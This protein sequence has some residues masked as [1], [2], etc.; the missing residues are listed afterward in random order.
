MIS[1]VR[2][3]FLY[4][5]G[6]SEGAGDMRVSKLDATSLRL[7]FAVAVSMT[8]GG[9]LERDVAPTPEVSQSTATSSVGSTPASSASPAAARAT[10]IQFAD[11]QKPG[12]G[13]PP[14]ALAYEAAFTLWRGE[15]RGMI[16]RKVAPCT[17]QPTGAPVGVTVEF[18][19]MPVFETNWPSA[20]ELVPG[21][22]YDPLVPTGSVCGSSDWVWADVKVSTDAAPGHYSLTLGDLPVALRVENIK[23]PDRPTV[24]LYIGFQSFSALC[25]HRLDRNSP[26]RDQGPLVKK[27]VDLLRA[28]RIEPFG[29]SLA[30]PKIRDGRP[31]ID[32]WQELGGSFRQLVIDGA[33]APPM[34]LSGPF[35]SEKWELRPRNWEL[36]RALPAWER[37]VRSSTAFA[38]SWVYVT[39]EPCEGEDCGNNPDPGLAGT[40]ARAQLLR[41]YAPSLRRMVTHAPDSRLADVIDVFVPL[42]E[43]FKSKEIEKLRRDQSFWIY[44]SCAS[45]THCN[46]VI[47]GEGT[48]SPDLMLD[49]PSIHARAFPIVAAALGAKAAL[50]YTANEGYGKRDVWTDQFDFGGNGDGQLVYPGIKGERGFTDN[51]A[52]GSIRLKMLRQGM[53]DLERMI[54]AGTL[55][56]IFSGEEEK[57]KNWSKE[58]A[59]ID[60]AA[61]RLPK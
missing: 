12:A 51:Q 60:R 28:H 48:G 57:W 43:N 42:F 25:G 10:A 1:Q 19:S 27:Y 47:E 29:Q 33:I 39:D 20:K 14:P 2:K 30:V 44:G 46:N 53:F 56:S 17:D 31:D 40:W 18:F 4:W 55:Q 6:S 54:K 16:L 41:T 26:V 24:P 49:R 8:L 50:Y 23:M 32:E 45:N 3:S 9:C 7:V 21:D 34:I 13:L 38:G 35:A 5:W 61:G 22:H 52:V 58:H 36:T 11:L 15:T 59:D 37:L